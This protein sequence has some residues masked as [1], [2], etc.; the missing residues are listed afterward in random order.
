[1][2]VARSRR[3]GITLAA[4][5]RKCNVVWRPS[6][7]L[8][9]SSA[10]SPWLTRGQHATWPAYISDLQ[11]RHTCFSDLSVTKVLEIS[12]GISLS[13]ALLYVALLSTHAD[14]QGVNISVTVFNCVFVCSFVRLRISP[15]RI[16]L[17]DR[18]GRILYCVH[19]TQY[20]LLIVRSLVIP[21]ALAV[22]G[23]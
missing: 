15:P 19:S 9:L 10:Y 12:A 2:K 6:V 23:E 14:R 16:K 5:H 17:A 3:P 18:F 11:D 8:S 20:S 4:S 1:M 13:E 7:C 21:A 22:C